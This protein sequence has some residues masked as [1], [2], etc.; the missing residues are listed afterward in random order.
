MGDA[1]CHLGSTCLNC[2]Q[3]IGDELEAQGQCPRCGAG[4]D[5]LVD[6][7]GLVPDVESLRGRLADRGI[8]TGP[9]LRRFG[10]RT[11]DVHDPEG[12]RFEFWSE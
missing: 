8:A 1:A 9:I 11:L 7:G 2:G 12:N 4:P 5:G 10:S 6:N 3:F